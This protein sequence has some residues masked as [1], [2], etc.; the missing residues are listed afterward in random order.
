MAEPIKIRKQMKQFRTPSNTIAVAIVALD[1]LMVFTFA[2]VAIY[3]D[4]WTVTLCAIVLI[5]GRQVAFSN[6][7]HA[8]AHHALFRSKGWNN[9]IEF[10]A[11]YLIL[12]SVATN[13]EPHLKHHAK[14]LKGSPERFDDL[15]GEFSLF[16]R[17]FL[18]R[19]WVVFVR[20]LLGYNGL[21]FMA[22][23]ARN[24]RENPFFLM[25]LGLY[26]LALIG[27]CYW[28][29]FLKYFLLYWVLPLLWVYPIFDRW[30]Q[31]SDHFEVR[32]VARN[33]HGL[34]YNLLTKPHEVNHYTHHL[35]PSIPFYRL[36]AATRYLVQDDEK[37]ENTSSFIDFVKIVYR[38][39]SGSKSIQGDG[40]HQDQWQQIFRQ[41]L[42]SQN[43]SKQTVGV[44][45]VATDRR[46]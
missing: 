18:G 17:G 15:Y 11:G 22:G 45:E 6:L 1:Y 3:F 19:T 24:L 26:W 9:S 13:R 37:I 33:H 34:F 7:V 36:E 44:A 42:H 29:G 8:A 12:D 28:L 10:F 38:G 16:D 5:A 40:L 14:F 25:R 21:S 30:A 2:R 39:L 46:S 20:P 4:H 23:T 43:Q 35:Y 32:G 41:K 27:T 31:V